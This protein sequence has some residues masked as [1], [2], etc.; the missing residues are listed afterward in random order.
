MVVECTVAPAG[1]GGS[2]CT[3]VLPQDDMCTMG[4]SCGHT[5]TC[6]YPNLDT[7]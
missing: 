5:Y 1:L 3:S 2:I 4:R 7:L 6:I